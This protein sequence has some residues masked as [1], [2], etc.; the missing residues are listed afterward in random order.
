MNPTIMQVTVTEANEILSNAREAI[1]NGEIDDE[2]YNELRDSCTRA[3]TDA[4]AE[5]R[6]AEREQR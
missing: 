3:F 2:Q 5:Q 4:L 1:L 6:R